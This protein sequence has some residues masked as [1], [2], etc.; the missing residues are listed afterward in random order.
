[1]DKD[2]SPI[3]LEVGQAYRDVDEFEGSIDLAL[4]WL[5]LAAENGNVDALFELGMMYLDEEQ[6]SA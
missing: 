6:Q 3:Q 1:M 5:G 2:S 4:K